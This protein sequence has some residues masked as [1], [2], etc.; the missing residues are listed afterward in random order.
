MAIVVA[1]AVAGRASWSV[2]SVQAGVGRRRMGNLRRLGRHLRRMGL[3]RCHLRRKGLV[4]GRDLPRLGRDLRRWGRLGRDL[5]RLDL[6]GRD[7]RGLELLRG[8]LRRLNLRRYLWRLPL[9]ATAREQP[10]GHDEEATANQRR[11]LRNRARL[12]RLGGIHRGEGTRAPANRRARGRASA[13]AGERSASR[14]RA[15]VGSPST[16]P[17]VRE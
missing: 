3:L 4:V 6:L 1:G 8:H 2:L 11:G 14:V 12:P 16:R 5:R 15:S 9:S 17:E 10:G 7:L 13:P